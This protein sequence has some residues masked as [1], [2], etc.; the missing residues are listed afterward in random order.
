MNHSKDRDE[1]VLDGLEKFIIYMKHQSS[2]AV[3]LL[4][5]I[6]EVVSSSLLVSAA[7]NKVG[8]VPLPRAQHSEVKIMGLSDRF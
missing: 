3:V 8:I 6:R 7:S 1:F 4:L 2:E 5:C